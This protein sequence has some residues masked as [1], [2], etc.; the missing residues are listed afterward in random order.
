ME[1]FFNVF[2]AYLLQSPI[3]HLFTQ[4][5][6]LILIVYI[7]RYI[8]Y[9]ITT[10]YLPYPSLRHIRGGVLGTKGDCNIAINAINRN[11][12]I[13]MPN[14]VLFKNAVNTALINI[15][16]FWPKALRAG[17]LVSGFRSFCRRQAAS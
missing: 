8:I 2:T 12:L 14:T 10:Y 5:K 6:P 17:R 7:Y 1:S 11:L 15:S 16:S 3:L 9:Y 4:P 13:S